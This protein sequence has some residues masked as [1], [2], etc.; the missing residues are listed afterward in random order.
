M[1]VPHSKTMKKG[2]YINPTKGVREMKLRNF[3]NDCSIVILGH[4]VTFP[5]VLTIYIS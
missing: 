4:I 5:K 2:R 3:L 1:V